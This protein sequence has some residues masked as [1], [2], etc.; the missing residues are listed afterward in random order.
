MRTLQGGKVSQAIT[1]TRERLRTRLHEF[2][3]LFSDPFTLAPNYALPGGGAIRALPD[4]KMSGIMFFDTGKSHPSKSASDQISKWNSLGVLL[5]GEK[6]DKEKRYMVYSR[7]QKE[8]SRILKQETA[9]HEYLAYESAKLLGSDPMVA[10]YTAHLVVGAGAEDFVFM[11]GG[12]LTNICLTDPA[13]L[14]TKNAELAA[15]LKLMPR[16]KP[17]F[18]GTMLHVVA[19][20]G[21]FFTNNRADL[22]ALNRPYFAHFYDG[23][24]G[25]NMMDGELKFQSALSRIKLYWEFASSLYKKNDMPNT[26]TALGHIMHLVQDLH[27]PAHVHND[28]HGPGNRDSLEAWT[29][30]SDYLHIAR[31]SDEPNVRIWNGKTLSP[32]K[33]DES[34]TPENLSSKLTEFIDAMVRNT[35]RFRSVD[36]VGTDPGQDMQ[37]KLTAQEC[38]D[39]AKVLIPAAI[40]DAAQLVANF[41]DFHRRN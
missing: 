22:D 16:E 1:R 29:T 6:P 41:L 28:T 23:N 17:T 5:P 34:W 37:G 20:L 35:Q 39:Q 25:L 21:R 31:L 18:F 12:K 32:P 27:A 7:A 33:P 4:P 24:S 40:V 30:R 8:I 15:A 9:C 14:K 13:V 36:A 26:F 3:D 19:A 38:Y 2:M 11:P 10:R